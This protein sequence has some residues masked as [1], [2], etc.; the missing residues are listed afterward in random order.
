MD[1]SP[2]DYKRLFAPTA[3]DGPS[4]LRNLPRPFVLRAAHLDG[5]R[6]N[7]GERFEIGLNLFDVRTAAE[8][9]FRRAVCGSVDAE[10]GS[11]EG[12]RSLKLPL[13][14]Y[15]RRI[16]R[17]RVRFLT[18]TELKAAPQPSFRALFARI[19]DRVSTLRALYGGGVLPIDFRGA[20]ER[21]EQVRMTRCDLEHVGGER[22]SRATGQRHPLAGFIGV[23]EYEGELA[24][25]APYLEAARFTGVGRQTVW[26]KGEIAWE[27]I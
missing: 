6:F 2:A 22:L 3:A 19:R 14:P 12:D 13:T 27:E 16:D 25:F 15:D 18:P 26:G 4:G 1:R 24:E 9:A 20:G 21:A 23:A 5:A 10:L 17:V 11:I 8:A 7:P